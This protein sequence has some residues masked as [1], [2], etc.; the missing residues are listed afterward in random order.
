MDF[1]CPNMESIINISIFLYVTKCNVDLILFLSILMFLSG[2]GPWSPAACVCIFG[3][4]R[5]TS[6]Y[7]N[8]FSAW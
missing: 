5:S 6:I 7:L 1:A 8:S 2:F 3:V 4:T